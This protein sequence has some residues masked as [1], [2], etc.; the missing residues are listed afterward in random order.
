MKWCYH[1]EETKNYSK[2]KQI[3]IRVP[4]DVFSRLAAAS[5]IGGDRTEWIIGAIT[6]KLDKQVAGIKDIHHDVPIEIMKIIGA[7]RK[8][9]TAHSCN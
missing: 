5:G 8:D 6:E 3:N 1:G 2:T 4:N 7:M 9:R